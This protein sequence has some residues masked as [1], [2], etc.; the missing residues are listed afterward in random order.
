[1]KHPKYITLLILL[2]MSALILWILWANTA[3]MLTETVSESDRLP[4]AFDGYRIAQISDL[5][6]AELG[7]NNRRLITILQAAEPDLIVVTGDMVDSSHT[8]LSVAVDLLRQAIEIA[9]CIAVTGNHEAWISDAAYTELETALASLGI[10]ILHNESI[11]LTQGNDSITL[12][13]IDD[14]AYAERHG[15]VDA[16]SSA[17][18]LRALFPADQYTVLLSHRPEFFEE[19]CRAGLDLVFSG[20]AHGGQFR[21]PLIGGLVAPGQGLLPI[22]DAGAFI[23]GN[24]HMIVSRGIGNSLIPIRFNNRPEIILVTLTLN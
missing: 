22:Y 18:R 1:M 15:G 11:A 9:P 10:P 6:N 4:P 14:P 5:H 24:T 20:H 17:D 7:K 13:G 16:A 8:D 19:Y 3:P 23:D 21:L 2:L 12:L